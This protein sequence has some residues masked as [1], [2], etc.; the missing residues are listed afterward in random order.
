MESTKDSSWTL[1]T[2]DDNETFLRTIKSD[3]DRI[4]KP[5]NNNEEE[6]DQTIYADDEIPVEESECLEISD[7]SDQ[8]SDE[9]IYLNLKLEPTL[10]LL[11]P[12]PP[13]SKDYD[14]FNNP[15]MSPSDNGY[16]S[17]GS[18]NSMMSHDFYFNNDPDEFLNELFPSLI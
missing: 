16:E 9:D 6:N 17:H 7:L 18:P 4:Y 1:N 11:S 13:L 12:I 5:L 8:E 14:L 10:R 2:D 15:S 3:F